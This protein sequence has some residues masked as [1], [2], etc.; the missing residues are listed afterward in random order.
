MGRKSRKAKSFAA[1]EHF[2]GGS[3]N[4]RLHNS[5]FAVLK[6]G[7]RGLHILQAAAYFV[8]NNVCKQTK[9]VFVGRNSLSCVVLT[10][11]SDEKSDA[12]RQHVAQLCEG[13]DHSLGDGGGV[14]QD[15]KD[16]KGN[17]TDRSDDDCLECMVS[18]GGRTECARRYLRTRLW[19]RGDRKIRFCSG[20]KTVQK[21]D[22]AS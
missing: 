20:Q 5:G 16:D 6:K 18:G 15:E 11:I 22:L 21:G 14:A 8:M 13:S 3:L 2:S 4:A 1:F 12:G 9:V 19:Q 7:R 17:N 10:F